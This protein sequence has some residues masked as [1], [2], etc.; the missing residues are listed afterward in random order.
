MATCREVVAGAFEAA[1]GE[2]E[3]RPIAGSFEVFGFDLMLD[4]EWN[5]YASCTTSRGRLA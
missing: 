1:H 4:D 2:M 3:F 5:V